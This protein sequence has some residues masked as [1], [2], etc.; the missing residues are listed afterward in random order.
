MINF[1]DLNI[2]ILQLMATREVQ[3]DGV[4]GNPI[5]GLATGATQNSYAVGS[6]GVGSNSGAY[7]YQTTTTQYQQQPTTTY[8]STSYAPTT[9]AYAYGYGAGSATGYGYSTGGYT[10]GVTGYT[11]G[12]TGY[13]A[14]YG[15]TGG[16]TTTT[17]TT[18]VAH[19]PQVVNTVVNTGKEVIKGESRI[20]YVPF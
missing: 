6:S 17:T 10:T 2:K 12:V 4:T 16:Y 11:T 8:T 13:G 19:Q 5:G 20:E 18:A 9:G 1:I 14:A 15:T 3:I 7:G